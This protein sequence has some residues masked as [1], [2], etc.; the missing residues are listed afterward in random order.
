MRNK[1]LKKCANKLI[2][3]YVRKNFDKIVSLTNLVNYVNT[4]S[5]YSFTAKQISFRLKYAVGKQYHTFRRIDKDAAIYY[6][7]KKNE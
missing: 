1:K 5:S 6:I 3:A 2:L 4:K 7:F